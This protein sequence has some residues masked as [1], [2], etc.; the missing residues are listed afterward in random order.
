MCTA[1]S[2]KLNSHY[3]G[4]NLD[5]EHTFGEKLVVTPRRYVFNFKNGEKSDNHY[6]IIGIG[7]CEENYPLY[8]DACNEK[9]LCIAGLNFPGNA[10]YNN[11]KPGV[12]NIAS[13][14]LIPR[15]LCSCKNTGEA[16]KLFKEINITNAAFN[17]KLMPTPLHWIV[18]DKDKTLTVE[19]TADGIRVF[20]NQIGVLTNS[21]PFDMQIFNLTN[22]MKVSAN[23]AEN[24]F[25]QKVNLLPYSNGMGGMGLPGDLSSASRF[26]RA[27]FTKMNADFGIGECEAVNRFFHVLYSVYQQKGCVR[28]A[29]GLEKTN[30]SCCY[31]ANEG[32]CYYTTYDNTTINA[33]DI[34]R[35]D[36]EGENL[37]M[38]NMIER[39]EFNIQN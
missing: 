9:G 18:A 32:I 23:Q 6:A 38:Y 8:F 12:K 29:V 14:E 26:V 21:P 34:N 4:R 16:E 7:I 30:Y 24:A 20:D 19:Q 10:V 15:V 25:S 3:F 39:G 37:T 35:A 27:A 22:Y 17:E 11:E 36:V 5:Y 1:I 33:V 31:N 2:V 28:T 13:F